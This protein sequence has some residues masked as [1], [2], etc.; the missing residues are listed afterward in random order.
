MKIAF[1]ALGSAVKYTPKNL[2]RWDGTGEFYKMTKL[3]C[4]MK[5]VEKVFIVSRSDWAKAPLEAKEEID[6]NNKIVDMWK[7]VKE[8]AP[9]WLDFKDDKGLVIQPKAHKFIGEFWPMC[10]K[11]MEIHG[12][13]DVGVF[14]ISQGYHTTTCV[15]QY[16]NGLMNPEKKASPL[17]M[18]VAYAAPVVHF[19]NMWNGPWLALATDPRYIEKTIHHRDTVNLPVEIT[20]Q[21]E[22]EKN[23]KHFPVYDFYE[24]ER[25]RGEEEEE[26]KLVRM[27]ASGIEKMSV[28]YMKHAD[29]TNDRPRKF[30]VCSMEVETTAPA[31]KDF[32]LNQLKE[33]IINRDKDC[34]IEVYGKWKPEKVKDMPQFKGYLEGDNILDRI[35]EETRYSLVLPQKAG[36][37]T[38]K[39][40]ELLRAGV[41]PFL[42]PAYDIQNTILPINHYIRV[43]TPDELFQKME[44]LDKQPEKRI[45]LVHVLREQLLPGMEDGLPIVNCLNAAFKRCNLDLQ[46]EPGEKEEIKSICDL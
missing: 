23:W 19:I 33:W 16:L 12:Q 4:S 30:V 32:R 24:P 20:G 9:T 31:D 37:C 42:H 46:L 21:F 44:Y 43:K 34:K 5:N 18:T 40:A 25:H 11:Q 38:A 14:F 41:V 22:E 28:C 8:D 1:G 27:T 29:V 26:T 39:Y 3:L 6:P 45:K 17:L 10:Q 13:P 15:P 2:K 7:N 36:W 35:F